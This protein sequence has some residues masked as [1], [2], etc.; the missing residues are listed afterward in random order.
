MLFPIIIIHQR[1]RITLIA[2]PLVLSS[3][4][5]EWERRRPEPSLSNAERPC[6]K[7]FEKENRFVYPDRADA[8]PIDPEVPPWPRG[9]GEG[10]DGFCLGRSCR[11]VTAG[12]EAVCR[13][14][15]GARVLWL[16]F[17][18]RH[19]GGRSGLAGVEAVDPGRD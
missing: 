7:V 12:Q 11:A 5:N 10:D 8:Q 18:D 16:G 19:Q 13:G 1:S 14:R 6:R 15:C 3:K 2:C 9:H 4:A 17:R